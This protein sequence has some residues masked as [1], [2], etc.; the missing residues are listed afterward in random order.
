V[1]VLDGLSEGDIVLVGP[2]E[3]LSVGQ[4][5]KITGKES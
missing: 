1:Q 5:V 2:I 3:G 4:F